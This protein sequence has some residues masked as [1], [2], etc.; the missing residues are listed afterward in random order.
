MNIFNKIKTRIICFFMYT[1]KY[2][3]IR[4]DH[5][6][7]I[8]FFNTPEH[9]N[10]GDQALTFAELVFVKENIPDLPCYEVTGSEMLGAIFGIGGLINKNDIIAIHAGGYLG[11]IWF[12]GGEKRCRKILKTYKHN[13]IIIFPQ[14][15]YYSDDKF[16]NSELEKSKS[17][18]SQCDNLTIFARE[19]FSYNFLKKHFTECNI[20]LVP[21]MVL[22]LQKHDKS[23]LRKGVLLCLRKDHEKT[24]ASLEKFFEYLQGKNMDFICTDTTIGK[25]VSPQDRDKELMQKL[26][27]FSHAELVITDRMHGMVFSAITGT[28]CVVLKSLSYKTEGVYDWISDVKSIKMI[29]DLN[30]LDGAINEVLINKDCIYEPEKLKYYFEPLIKEVQNSI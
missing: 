27:E 3:T 8:V 17:I 29:Q 23:C 13:K 25:H 4:R 12:G 15:V 14:T 6:K 28:P 2:K 19:K 21:D 24:S 18:Y 7:K 26:D 16:G 30:E 20:K 11:T 5:N 22:Y 1:K 9:D 10:L